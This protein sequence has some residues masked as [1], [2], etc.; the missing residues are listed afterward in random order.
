MGTG[1]TIFV[2]QLELISQKGNL[3][4]LNEDSVR[5]ENNKNCR[6]R[7]IRNK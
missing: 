5:K 4:T 6:K 3:N 2:K 7:N 1:K